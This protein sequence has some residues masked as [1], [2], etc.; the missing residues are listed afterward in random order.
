M[1]IDNLLEYNDRQQLHEWLQTHHS[2][3]KQCWV[4]VYR[5]K[6]KPVGD[7]LP[8]VEVVEEAL[9]YG[10]IDSTLKRIGDGRLAQRLSPRRKGSHWTEL[11]V[12]RCLSLI[13][14]N[15]MTES[16]LQTMPIT[17]GTKVL[18]NTD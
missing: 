15:L 1:E 4:A 17:T 18:K 7:C 3:A 9:C 10:W 13:E 14:R 6:L 11:N 16:G 12:Q 5:G 8:Y 2:Q